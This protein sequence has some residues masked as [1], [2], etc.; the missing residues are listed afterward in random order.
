MA[1]TYTTSIRHNPC[2]CSTLIVKRELNS[3]SSV[4]YLFKFPRLLT[5]GP[6]RL[7]IPSLKFTQSFHSHRW[8][9]THKSC[10]WSLHFFELPQ[11]HFNFNYIRSAPNSAPWVPTSNIH[12]VAQPSIFQAR[13]H[14][15]QR[16]LVVSWFLQTS[17]CRFRRLIPLTELAQRT[18]N[19]ARYRLL[20]QPQPLPVRMK[21]SFKHP[22]RDIIGMWLNL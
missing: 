2:P 18:H 9:S 3:S 14:V 10:L 16:A 11:H 5:S 19:L 12:T 1:Y 4:I 17:T 22:R 6:S 20:A 7:L 13:S 8:L 21:A 15:F